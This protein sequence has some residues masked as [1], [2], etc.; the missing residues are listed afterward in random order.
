MVAAATSRNPVVLQ[1]LVQ[2]YPA[3]L[4]DIRDQHGLS[5]VGIAAKNGDIASLRLLLD[6]GMSPN[7]QDN[8]GN[9]PLHH[10]LASKAYACTELLLEKDVDEDLTNN[11]GLTAWRILP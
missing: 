10:A 5:L 2:R 9:S 6:C 7:T 11:D 8:Q 3:G 4:K 1:E